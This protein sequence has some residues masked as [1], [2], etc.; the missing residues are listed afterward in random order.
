METAVIFC[1]DG[2]SDEM[3]ESLQNAIGEVYP[4]IEAEMIDGG[5][6]IYHFVIGII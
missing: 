3:Q 6:K 2:I 4:N 5:Q 1:G